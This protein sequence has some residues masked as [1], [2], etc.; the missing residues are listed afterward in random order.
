MSQSSR[1]PKPHSLPV[2]LVAELDDLCVERE[3]VRGTNQGLGGSFR[4]QRIQ[5]LQTALLEFPQPMRGSILA[6][7][8][9]E[10]ILEV[11]SFATVWRA[12]LI[13]SGAECA[14]QV[15]HTN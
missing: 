15:F 1:S 4:D 3:Q 10:R 8:R 11:G 14:V 5:E 7:A 6:G 2:E 12:T 9:L 13:D